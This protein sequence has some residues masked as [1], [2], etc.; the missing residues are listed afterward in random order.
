MTGRVFACKSISEGIAIGDP[1]FATYCFDSPPSCAISK[2]EVDNEIARFHNAWKTSCA[3]LSL[4]HRQET[5]A[6]VKDI[7]ISQIEILKDPLVFIE[8]ANMIKTSLKS[9]EFCLFSVVQIHLK[10]LQNN[11]LFKQR[12]ADIGGILFLILKHLLAFQS[13]TP[14]NNILIAKMLTTGQFL[15]ITQ[16][17]I[18]GIITQYEETC[19]HV[20]IIARTKGIPFVSDV[21]IDQLLNISPN[22]QIIIDAVDSKIIIDPS[23]SMK[24]DYLAKKDFIKNR[25]NSYISESKQDIFTK[26][27]H[28][29]NIWVSINDKNDIAMLHMYNSPRIGL[30]RTEYLAYSSQTILSAQKQHDVYKKILQMS[31]KEVIIR[32]FDIEGDSLFGLKASVIKNPSLGLR[33]TRLLLKRKEI[34][35]NQLRAL[36]LAAPYGSLKILLPMISDA[37][38]IIKVKKIIKT[39]Q[40]EESLCHISIPLGVMV[41]IPSAVFMIDSILDEVDF[42]CIGSNDL[43][44]F[45]M[46]ADRTNPN[47]ADIYQ[48]V[49]PSTIQMF[50][51]I[52]NAVKR[53]DKLCLL[54]G[55]ITNH[56]FLLMILI[57][58]DICNISVS[59]SM[60]A[61]IAHQIEQLSFNSCTDILQR[62][63]K[64]I[65]KDELTTVQNSIERIKSLFV[66]DAQLPN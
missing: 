57:G 37:G 28:K 66:I 49:Y 56:P 51:L 9:A 61:K 27:R 15:T 64:C 16:N 53:K 58:L 4:L 55:E 34:L 30:C 6:T 29:V 65:T 23:S 13:A 25:W 8:T 26:D 19:S 44:Q 2:C 36:I 54:C 42:V 35:F 47:M 3:E 1:L 33:G 17:V 63:L 5:D 60:M 41:E 38:E 22:S 40:E 45:S 31:N 11:R 62:A 59:L 50:Y 7:I 52:A 32:L 20:A 21:N 46:A 18:A 24:K 43:I 14:Q 12:T 10:T 39:I 48:S